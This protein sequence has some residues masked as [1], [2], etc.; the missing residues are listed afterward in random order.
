V[1]YAVDAWGDRAHSERDAPDPSRPTIVVS[2]E[3]DAAGHAM[4]YEQTFPALLERDLGVQVVDVAAGG[5]GTDQAFLRLDDALGRLRRPIA[6]VTTFLPVMLHRNLQDYRPLLVLRGGTLQLVPAADGFF[7]RLRLRDLL[8][9]ELP[10]LSESRL[11][12]SLQLTSA[13]LRESVRRS[14]ERGATPLF[15]VPSVGPARPFEEHREAFILRE[16]FVEPR[17]PFVLVDLPREELVPGDDH[18]GPLAH[19]RLADAIE[20]ALPRVSAQ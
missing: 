6:A 1:R 15:V 8:V 16:L 3:S 11:R 2:G 4:E 7:A 20:A 9:N 17:L 13:I 12:E 18:P 10:W 19:R 14:R 5:Y